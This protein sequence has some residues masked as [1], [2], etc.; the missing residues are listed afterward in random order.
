[1]LSRLL[2]PA[3][4]DVDLAGLQRLPGAWRTVFRVKIVI[5]P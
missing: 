3:D 2:A 5:W 4:E 1:L